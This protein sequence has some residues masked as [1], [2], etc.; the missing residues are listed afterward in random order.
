[1]DVMNAKMKIS[2]IYKISSKVKP[3][4]EYFG[5]SQDIFGRLRMHL[6][7]LR[8]GKHH[9]PKLQHHYN[10]YGEAD[11]IFQMVLGCDVI[12]LIKTEQYF[13]DSYKPY[14]NI[15]PN[16][17]SHLGA[18]R[19]PES[20]KRCSLAKTGV[21]HHYYGKH[22]SDGHKKALSASLKGRTSYWKGKKLSE[23][24]KEK[25]SKARVGRSVSEETRTKISKINKGKKRSDEFRQRCRE[26]ESKK[27][28]KKLEEVCVN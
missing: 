1:M 19:S 18:K 8:R 17:G 14:F 27:R 12:D 10:K 6:R 5:S 24:T 25:M 11:L 13:L 9:S 3:S 4:R 16:A 20:C 15:L 7:D 28:L 21:N 26:R 2:G 22:L 23:E